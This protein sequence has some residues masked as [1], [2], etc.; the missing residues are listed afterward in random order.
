MTTICVDK[1]GVIA[2]DGRMTQGNMIVR[3]DYDKKYKFGN[4]YF[5]LAG[6]V[7]D[8][9]PFMIDCLEGGSDREYMVSGFM[10]E[11]GQL[12]EVGGGG[13]VWICDNFGP[14]AY[15]SGA[16]HAITA[17]DCGLS[18]REAIKMAAKRDNCTGGKIRTFKTR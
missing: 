5:F 10:Y 9:E 16:D 12:Y 11:N 1:D 4:A 6:D 3:D 17:M 15:G 18:A 14:M 8:M 13:G 7:K 2:Y